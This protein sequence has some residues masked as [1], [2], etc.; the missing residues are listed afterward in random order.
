MSV[1][2]LKVGLSSDS[3]I[4]KKSIALI[5]QSVGAALKIFISH[6]SDDKWVA[7]QISRLLEI[8]GH[9]TFLDEKDIKTGDSIDASIQV[10]LKGSDHLLL[11]L[12]P[13]S[14][15]SQWVF[16]EL[17]GAKALG[18]HIVPIL[19]HIGGNEIP[20]AISQ[21]LARDINDIDKYFSELKKL[22][23][24]TKIAPEKVASETA[25][26]DA[27]EK[28]S[29]K[30]DIKSF[31]G[32]KVGEK[33]QISKVEH[34]TDED[35][36]VFPKWTRPMDKYSGLITHITAFSKRGNAFLEVSGDN[37]RWNTDWLSKV[38]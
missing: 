32:F 20:H 30:S 33:V 24:L 5:N 38:E 7:R 12:S 25:K 18:K 4:T 36:L 3:L 10:N 6:S 21:L 34:L 22:D 2:G 16:I 13:S 23:E 37:F 8:D 11:L 17:G 15:T 19:F 14:L 26:S 31:A 35:K 9:T 27:R 28:R 29:A 1:A